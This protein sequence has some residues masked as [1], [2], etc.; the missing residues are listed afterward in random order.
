MASK[1]PNEMTTIVIQPSSWKTRAYD[2]GEEESARRL[3]RQE[4]LL[5]K[6]EPYYE[7]RAK[8]KY[9]QNG[10][11]WRTAKSYPGVDAVRHIDDPSGSK[12]TMRNS[13]SVHP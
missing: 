11:L 3:I 6:H 1:H 9:D 13:N 10:K 7:A 2:A 8:I 5:K 4:V 12:R